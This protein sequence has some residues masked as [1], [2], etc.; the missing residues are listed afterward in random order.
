MNKKIRLMLEYKPN[1][2]IKCCIGLNFWFSPIRY[3]YETYQSV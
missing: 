2:L 3:I 1:V